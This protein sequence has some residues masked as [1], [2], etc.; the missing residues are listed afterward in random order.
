LIALVVAVAAC[1]AEKVGAYLVTHWQAVLCIRGLAVGD[2]ET[3]IEMR[4]EMKA[5]AG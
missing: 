5:V 2:F 4:Y 3:C 1:C